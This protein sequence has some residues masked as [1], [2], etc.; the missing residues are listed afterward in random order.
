[1]LQKRGYFK[2]AIL[3]LFILLLSGACKH[4][5][6]LQSAP[7]QENAL[8]WQISGKGLSKSSYLYGTIHMICPEDFSIS[9]TLKT[10][11][12]KTEKV[13]MELDMDDPA[14][15][16]K[17]LQ[18]SIMKDK[19]LKDLMSK[20]DY[21][22]LDK[23]MK[24]T[25]GMSLMIFNRM[26]PFTLMSLLYT[27]VLPCSR[28]ESYEQ[29]FM[30]MANQ[31][32]K[33]ILGLEKLEDQFAVFDKIPD[34]TEARMI[35]DMIENFGDQKKEFA[36]MTEAYKKKDLN[37]LAEML[38]ASPDMA[39][40]EDLLLVNRNKN[41]IPVM[42]KAMLVQSNFFAVGAGHLPGKDGVISLL[43]NAG[44]TIKAVE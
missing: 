15:T 9:D 43:R 41:W 13:Y 33:E 16:M 35:M 38:N 11:F 1:M 44:Y 14:I 30:T 7:V 4:A 39:G 42:E 18:L 23:F 31:Q 17:T 10:V 26:K 40:Y 34:T 36:K 8:L 12:S 28:M 27:K 32:K 29:S 24:D 25:I 20:E 5:A 21:A 19:S 3:S 22:H 37:G 6:G 2:F